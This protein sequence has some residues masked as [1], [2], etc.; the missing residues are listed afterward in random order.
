MPVIGNNTWRAPQLFMV[1]AALALATGI[2]SLI[3]FYIGAMGDGVIRLMALPAVII[4]G[5]LF[6]FSRKILF[7]L[8]I[9]FRGICDPIFEATRFSAG[10]MGI[11]GVVNALVILIAFLFFIERPRQ[12]ARTALP[13]WAPL[14]IIVLI[15]ALRAPEL[16]TGIKYFLVYLSYAAV[17]AVPF[18]LKECRKNLGYCA[19][20]I[21]LSSVLPALYG[22]VDFAMGGGGGELAGRIQSTF[23][24]PNIFAFYLVF[25]ISLVLYLLKGTVVKFSAGQ[26]LLLF[27]YMVALFTLLLLTKTRSAWAACLFVFA[28][29]GVVFERRF[30]IYLV[31]VTGLLLLVPA[32]QDRL[33]DLMQGNQRL[34]FET[35]NSYAWRKSIW[36]AGLGWMKLADM[37][38]GYGLESFRYYSEAFFPMAGT[39]R[40]GAHSV[41]VQWFFEAGLVG[42]LC[43]IWLFYRLLAMLKT[44]YRKDRLG[45]VIVI[46]IV[47]EYLVMSYS[48]NMLGYISF[49]WYF[50]FLMGAA[51]AV[52]IQGEDGPSA[53]SEADPLAPGSMGQSP[54]AR[55]HREVTA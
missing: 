47:F 46:T 50:W 51:C 27:A 49:N 8:I 7:L 26:R 9:F 52:N 43:S 54:T 34:Q 17:F 28:V 39:M 16:G 44:G 15:E 24:H 6:L 10:V 42:L 55:I 13:M 41:Y 36:E 25:V 45:T 19:L 11:G 18:Y 12:I 33:M 21:I 53:Q 14:M 2:G 29:Y 20:F 35:L 23:D 32:I 30:L 38:M 3:P 48:D 31:V 37:P 1:G 40:P 5:F 22:F 4:L